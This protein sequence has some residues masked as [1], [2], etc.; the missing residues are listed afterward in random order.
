MESSAARKIHI[1]ILDIPRQI[2]YNIKP[3]VLRSTD[4]FN[5]QNHYD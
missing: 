4:I 5:R 1:M 2:F 3:Y